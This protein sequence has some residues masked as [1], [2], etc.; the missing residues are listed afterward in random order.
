M[1]C[2]VQRAPCG[3]AR[4]RIAARPGT[5]FFGRSVMSFRSTYGP[6]TVTGGRAFPSDLI[7]SLPWQKT[8]LINLS[9]KRSCNSCENLPSLVRVSTTTTVSDATWT[10]NGPRLLFSPCALA[11]HA[12]GVADGRAQFGKCT[13]RFMAVYNEQ[14]LDASG[15]HFVLE[16]SLGADGKSLAHRA[17]AGSQQNEGIKLDTRNT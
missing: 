6:E 2:L 7:S 17:T 10:I 11:V 15:E 8:F 5:G 13:V 12:D 9:A 4:L 16:I 3:S 14:N 1:L